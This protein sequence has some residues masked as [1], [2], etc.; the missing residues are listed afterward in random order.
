[1]IHI[2]VIE[3]GVACGLVV[4]IFL[5]PL[6]VKR[7]YTRLNKRMKVIEDKLSKKH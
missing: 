1:M 4:L 6:I 7:S 2:S 3:L 5:I